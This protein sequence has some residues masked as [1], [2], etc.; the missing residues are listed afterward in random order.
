MRI[1]LA[2]ILLFLIVSCTDRPI[3]APGAQV[4]EIMQQQEIAWNDGDIDRFMEGYSDTICF[5]GSNGR[6]CG[7]DA[8]TANYGRSYPDRNAMG[9]L[10]FE[11]I[12]ILPVGS[13]N[14]WVTGGWTLFRSADTLQGGFSLLWAMERGG[15]RIVRDHSY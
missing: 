13:E 5:I 2:P 6:T 1:F 15:W 11:I 12:E 8:V 14:V 4:R 7:R 3:E 9:E 10:K